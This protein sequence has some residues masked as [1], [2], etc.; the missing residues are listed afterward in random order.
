[1]LQ[2]GTVMGRLV[3]LVVP[4]TVR[5]QFGN[6]MGAGICWDETVTTCA[7]SHPGGAHAK[8][9]VPT[10]ASG[11]VTDQLRVSNPGGLPA[12]LCMKFNQSITAGGC[13]PLAQNTIVFQASGVTLN[14]GASCAAGDPCP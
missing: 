8:G 12:T 5:D 14:Q 11:Q 4:Y 3:F 10:N 1:M 6:P 13:G 7:N 9:D 2:G